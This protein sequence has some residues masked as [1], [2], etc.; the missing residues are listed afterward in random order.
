[1]SKVCDFH[2]HSMPTSSP[3]QT[4]NVHSANSNS[5]HRLAGHWE[6][7]CCWNNSWGKKP[8][9]QPPLE[10]HFHHLLRQESLM[11]FR[12]KYQTKAR[13]SHSFHASHSVFFTVPP[14]HAT[15]CK[16]ALVI[17]TVKLSCARNNS[18]APSR[19][20]CK[21]SGQL[22]TCHSLLIL[23]V[24]LFGSNTYAALCFQI[25][26]LDKCLVFRQFAWKFWSPEARKSRPYWAQ[27]E[28]KGWLKIIG[29]K[30]YFLG[31]PV[32]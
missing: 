17:A 31:W 30:T 28:L 8:S 10:S 22:A 32:R 14:P 4:T 19:F 7:E 15:G 9:E 27:P 24:S 11:G 12:G 25:H 2:C 29:H 23:L 16:G 21:N 26:V 5:L 13:D 20:G 1:M 6:R 18:Q 3:H